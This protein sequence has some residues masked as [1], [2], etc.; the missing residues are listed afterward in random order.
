MQSGEVIFNKYLSLYNNY[1]KSFDH[2]FCI[3]LC[4]NEEMFIFVNADKI[5]KIINT[6]LSKNKQYTKFNKNKMSEKIPLLLKYNISVILI[7]DNYNVVA[8]HHPE[9]KFHENAFSFCFFPF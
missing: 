8:I 1:K 7:N 3:L 2:E 4:K 6:S 5:C 9:N